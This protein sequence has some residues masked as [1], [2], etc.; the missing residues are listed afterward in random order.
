VSLTHAIELISKVV[1]RSVEIQHAPP[2]PGDVRNTGADRTRA[3]QR[4]GYRPSTPLEA[5]LQAEFEWMIETI[6]RQRTQR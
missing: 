2:S 4:F 3:F 6:N 5:G 1:G